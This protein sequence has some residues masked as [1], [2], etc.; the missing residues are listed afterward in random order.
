MQQQNNSSRKKFIWWGAGLLA[1]L[2]ALRFFK[3]KDKKPTTTKML[4]QDG[5]LV[6]IDTRML[7]K[8]DRKITNLELQQWIKKNK[9]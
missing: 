2:S 5:K 8:S 4:T 1:S 3:A 6:E 9:T 7:K